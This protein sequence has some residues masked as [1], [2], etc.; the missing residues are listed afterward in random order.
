MGRY[1][2]MFRVDIGSVIDATKK[3]INSSNKR[4]ITVNSIV[5]S[6]KH[7]YIL[8][9]LWYKNGQTIFEIYADKYVSKINTVST[10]KESMSNLKE[11]G[12]VIEVE[13]FE[14]SRYY[15]AHNPGEMIE[16]MNRLMAQDLPTQQKDILSSFINF[17]ILNS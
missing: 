11:N 2:G 16:I 9:L 15:P 1:P 17:I 7:W 14:R 5:N 13:D 3:Y 10:L 8:E 6:E 12:L 4:T